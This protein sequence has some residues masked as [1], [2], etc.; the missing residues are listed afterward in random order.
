[1][2]PPVLLTNANVAT[3]CTFP[4]DLNPAL[5]KDGPTPGS[6][7][8]TFV[9]TVFCNQATGSAMHNAPE[10]QEETAGGDEQHKCAVSVILPQTESMG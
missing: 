7:S 8:P 2:L 1:M 6:E 9:S 4:C 10:L 3:M 5:L